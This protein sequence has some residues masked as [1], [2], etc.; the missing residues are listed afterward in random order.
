MKKE[1][2]KKIISIADSNLSTAIRFLQHTSADKI[3]KYSCEQ[4]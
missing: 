4:M 3:N 1:R 2:E